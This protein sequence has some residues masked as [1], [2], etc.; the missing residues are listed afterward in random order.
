VGEQLGIGLG[1]VRRRR[2]V[3][4]TQLDRTLQAW[5]KAGH[6]TGDEHAAHRSA[7]RAAADAVDAGAAAVTW[8]REQG[9]PGRGAHT[10]ALA[11]NTYA[12]LV[13]QL[14]PQ[15]VSDD[16]DSFGA[17]LAGLGAPAVR[18]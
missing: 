10:L 13:V 17:F 3:Q 15:E 12:Q 9:E 18:D 2:G 5:R 1:Q 11:S 7:L 16:G 6:L 8:G 14:G 4:R